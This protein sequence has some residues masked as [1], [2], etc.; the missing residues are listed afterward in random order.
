MAGRV[1]QQAGGG[2]L[3]LSGNLIEI[4]A[5]GTVLEDGLPT[6]R[7]ALLE[8]SDA[9]ALLAAG[10]AKF[11]GD[12]AGMADAENSTVRQGFL[13]SSNVVTSDEMLSL[14]ASTREAE[15]G[16]KLAQFYDQLMGQ[17]IAT[18]RNSR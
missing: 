16:A 7:V 11:L 6:A 1:L 18:F 5:D 4:L 8:A 10:G 12:S 3:T 17:A 9:N 2:D 13:E 14:M 15:S